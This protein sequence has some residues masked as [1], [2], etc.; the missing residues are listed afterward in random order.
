M[1]VLAII[2]IITVIA[3][4]NQNSFNKTIILANTA[5]DIAL[6]IRTSEQYGVGSRVASGRANIAY[7]LHIDAQTPDSFIVFADTAGGNACQPNAALNCK[8]GDGR[9]TVGSGPSTTDLI[10]QTVSIGNGIQITDM[11]AYDGHQ[12]KCKSRNSN[13]NITTLDIV[14]S[15]PNPDVSIATS[16]SNSGDT[17]DYACLELT[18]LQ[19]AVRYIKINAS[20]S[21]N[22][23][24]VS[25]RVNGD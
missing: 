7:G 21:I 24:A 1:V 5:Y 4:V 12:D 16:R 14:F 22:A 2:A 13:R 19:G 11:C 10:V 25:C 23:Q 17:F 20:G 15:R 9:Y 8:S 6:T 3:V 18:S